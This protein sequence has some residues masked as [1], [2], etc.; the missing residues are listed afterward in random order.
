MDSATATPQSSTRLV[1]TRIPDS[2]AWMR[3]DLL[4]RLM[5]FENAFA[6]AYAWRGE[7][8]GL[9][10][11]AGK[12]DIEAVRNTGDEPKVVK[13]YGS[14]QFGCTTCHDK[15]AEPYGRDDARD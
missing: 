10:L 4:V 2:W 6:V 5:P 14:V 3:P 1:L 12:P 9:G 7:Q 15:H 13:S 8:G 11:G